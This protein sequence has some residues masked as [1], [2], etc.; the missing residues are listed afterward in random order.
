MVPEDS[1]PWDNVLRTSGGAWFAPLCIDSEIR[2]MAT[3]IESLLR[4]ER[5]I[6]GGGLVV[7]CILSWV[8]IVT[9]AGTGMSVRRQSRYWDLECSFLSP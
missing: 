4:R 8:Y 3:T 2:V 6:I 1:K 7:I 9:G 5:W